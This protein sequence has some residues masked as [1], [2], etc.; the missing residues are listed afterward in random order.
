MPLG[1]RINSQH[2]SPFSL[3]SFFFLCLFVS[4]LFSVISLFAVFWVLPPLIPSLPAYLPPDQ[5]SCHLLTLFCFLSVPSQSR[6]RCRCD[7]VFSCKVLCDG[8]M[9]ARLWL[10]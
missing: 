1:M 3:S 6:S 5:F 9:Y 7:V 8:E 2:D 10:R 4:S